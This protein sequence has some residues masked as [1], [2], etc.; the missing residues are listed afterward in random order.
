MNIK[1]AKTRPDA[2]IPTKRQGDGCYDLYVC[3]DEEFVT[4]PPH[5]VKLVP[6]GLCSTFDSNYRI[7]FRERG[8]NT[9]SALLV[10]AGQIDSNFTGEWFVALYNGNDIPIEITKNVSEVMK[11]EDFIR[12]PYCK[13]VAQF[14]VEEVP[15]VTIEEVDADYIMNLKTERGAGMLG[16]SN[17]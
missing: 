13:A 6:T 10:M 11:E 12:V 9:K 1:F 16:S 17:K 7:G 4:I 15:Q 8:S 14:A 3:F 2:K 5:S